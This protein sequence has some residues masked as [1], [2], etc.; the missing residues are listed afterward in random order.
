MSTPFIDISSVGALEEAPTFD[1]NQFAGLSEGGSLVLPAGEYLFRIPEPGEDF[2]DGKTT[3]NQ[4]CYKLN[5]VV[6]EGP[7]AGKQ[8]KFVT[9]SVT[10]YQN[11]NASQAVELVAATG[12]DAKPTN[13]VEWL[14]LG[15]QLTGKTFRA[16]VDNRVYDK[17]TNTNLFKT[18]ADIRQRGLV[19]PDGMIKTRFVLTVDN[20]IIHKP[21][22][23]E[24]EDAMEKQAI[25]QGGR[26]LYANTQIVRYLPP[27]KAD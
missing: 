11:R 5:P 26:T 15:L 2:K 25:D 4:F 13:N 17:L 19:R 24:A 18:E 16:L 20:T 12:L 6:A 7:Y 9:A 8:L 21:D 10:V 3:K 22:D 23:P 1:W 27:K 14:K